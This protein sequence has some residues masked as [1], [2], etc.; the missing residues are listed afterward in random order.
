VA[1]LR[2]VVN[3]RDVAAVVA[4]R[5]RIVL[6]T[7]LPLSP[8]HSTADP[9]RHSAGEHTPKP[10]TITYYQFNRAVLRRPLEPGE[11]TAQTF[12]QACQRL[13]IRQSMGR[14]GCALDNAAIE[15]LHST[16]EFELR[17]RES[18]PTKAIT[19]TRVA[20]WIDEYNR[21]RR[22]SALGMQSP[23]AYE[24][25]RTRHTGPTPSPAGRAA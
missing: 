2:A 9:A 18:F 14:P 11:Y 23:I 21:D 15:A 17:S 10:S 20:A 4:T 3:S 16:L 19:R 5:A 1:E 13:G 22:H 24:L 7:T 6:W 8:R 25:A 12:R